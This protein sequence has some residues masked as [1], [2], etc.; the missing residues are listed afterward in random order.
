LWNTSK[1]EL[2]IPFG[3]FGSRRRETVRGFYDSPAASG[4]I[5]TGKGIIDSM[6]R[7]S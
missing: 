5:L 7:L 4:Q 3:G 1:E 2:L 6:R